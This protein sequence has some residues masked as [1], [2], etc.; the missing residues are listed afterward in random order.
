[1]APDVPSFGQA[2][3]SA[4]A[5][6]APAVFFEATVAVVAEALAQSGLNR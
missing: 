1:M 4:G 2:S 6:A 5:V 3:R